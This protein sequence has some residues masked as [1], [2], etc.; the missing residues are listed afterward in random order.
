MFDEN[1]KVQMLIWYCVI[2][3]NGFNS[4]MEYGSTPLSTLVSLTPWE[5]GLPKRDHV[6]ARQLYLSIH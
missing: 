6:I 3:Y 5:S 4:C 2:K 1:D